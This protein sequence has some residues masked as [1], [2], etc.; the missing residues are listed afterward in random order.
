MPIH[1]Y[2]CRSC[3]HRFEALVRGSTKPACPSCGSADLEQRLSLFA[4]SSASTRQAN[5]DT[6]RAASTRAQRDK[7]IADREEVQRHIQEHQ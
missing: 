2:E 4:V 3:R 1:E 7:K 5:V 6:A